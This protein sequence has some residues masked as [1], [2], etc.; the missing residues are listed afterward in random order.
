MY[1]LVAP[2]VLSPA[3]ANKA[4]MPCPPSDAA[5]INTVVGQAGGLF[6]TL[7]AAEIQ[8][9]I[10]GPAANFS[11]NIQVA[12]LQPGRIIVRCCQRG[13]PEPGGWWV[14]LQ[15]MPLGITPVRSGTAVLPNWNQNGNL[16]FFVVPEGCGIVIL[17]GQAA[18][19][20]LGGNLS[21]EG[22]RSYWQLGVGQHLDAVNDRVLPLNQPL[23]GSNLIN[24][25][26]QI[27]QGGATQI[28]VMEN[29]AG[30][31]FFNPGGAND[32]MPCIALIETGF[33]VELQ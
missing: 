8:T 24:V 28:Y 7:T 2:A 9:K 14:S 4:Q 29:G 33:D 20:A 13:S 5:S 6:P 27:L 22:Q 31:A 16:E 18:S 12:Q 15:D 26:G 30:A 3:V 21:T 17:E 1:S 10:L 19:Q 23:R 25:T 32:Y 11:G